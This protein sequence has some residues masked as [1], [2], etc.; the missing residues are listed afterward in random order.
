MESVGSRVHVRNV[1]HGLKKRKG[2]D[3]IHKV[4]GSRFDK[5]QNSQT[6]LG[7]VGTVSKDSSTNGSGYAGSGSNC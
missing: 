7:N 4:D 3:R 1:V 5:Q 2:K 6:D